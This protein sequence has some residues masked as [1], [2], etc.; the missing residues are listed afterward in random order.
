MTRRDMYVYL[1]GTM[2]SDPETRFWRLK[3]TE[4][5]ERRSGDDLGKIRTIDPF[6]G[7]PKEKVSTDG[8][9][10]AMP[11]KMLSKRDKWSLDRSDVML[12]YTLGIEKLDRQSIGTWSEFGYAGMALHIPIIVVAKE[13]QVVAH[14]FI[15]DMASMIVP[16]LNEAID[17]ILWLRLGSE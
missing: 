10:G 7:Q 17:A 3:A 16:T 4:E 1:C 13:R 14:P 15:T 8:L 5:L 9:H 11:G 6:R 12:L 2:T